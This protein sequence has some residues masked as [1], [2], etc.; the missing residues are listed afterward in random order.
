[1]QIE[2]KKISSEVYRIWMLY[3]CAEAQSS[4]AYIM[5]LVQLYDILYKIINIKKTNQC[6]TAG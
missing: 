5:L 1:M 6:F 4:T 2:D 3:A